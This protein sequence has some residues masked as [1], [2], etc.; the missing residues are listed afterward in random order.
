MHPFT[1]K[2]NAIE[3][4]G[5]PFVGIA[6]KGSCAVDGQKVH[7]GESF[8]ALFSPGADETHHPRFLPRYGHPQPIRIRRWSAVISGI[9]RRMISYVESWSRASRPYGLFLSVDFSCS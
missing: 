7:D 5:D 8:S 1:L 6:I 4:R 9:K 2:E 3:S